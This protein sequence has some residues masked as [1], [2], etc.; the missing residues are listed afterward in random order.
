M[1]VRGN[2][3]VSE[4]LM[5]LGSVDG[6]VRV[7]GKGMAL[8]AKKGSVILGNAEAGIVL[9]AGEVFGDVEGSIV[10]LYCTA[11]VHGRISA[12]RLI[13]DDGAVVMNEKMQVGQPPID[14]QPLHG[15]EEGSVQ[16]R[17]SNWP[18]ISHLPAR[19]RLNY[20]RARACVGR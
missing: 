10:R 6:D 8:L 17:V 12:R 4:S 13:V 18:N 3:D 9:L 20:I 15:A 14:D 19:D 5:V 2:I 16:E 1:R 7:E 11:T